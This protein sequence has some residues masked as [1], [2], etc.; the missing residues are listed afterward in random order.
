MTTEDLKKIWPEWQVEEQIGR[1][2]YGIVYKAIRRDH[3]V[4]NFAAIKVISIPT[5]AS[6][7]D[8][9]RSEGFDIDASRAYFEEIVNSFV[10]EIQLMV[11]LKGIQNIVSVED[12]KVVEKTD[13]IGWDIYIR[14][15]LLTPFNTYICDKKL[16]EAEV[17]KLGCDI[18]SALE[19]CGKR[20]IIHRDI[21]PENIFVNDFGDFK[22]GDFGIA[23]KLE[24]STIGFSQKGTY[25]Y[26]APEVTRGTDYD[27]RVDIYSLGIVL[28]RLMNNNRLPFLDTEKQLLNP[29]ER[30]NAVERRI[31]GEALLPPCDAS[32]EMADLILRA[33]A[34]DPDQRFSS[35]SVM[36]HNLMIIGKGTYNMAD[37]NRTVSVR[38]VPS[39]L[40]KTVSVNRITESGYYQQGT[41]VGNFTPKKKN[42]LPLAIAAI[43]IVIVLAIAGVFAV[44]MMMN[45]GGED[46]S[47]DGSNNVGNSGVIGDRDEADSEQEQINSILA[48]AEDLAA[49]NDYKGALNIIRDGLTTHP[50]S[51]ELQTKADE[52]TAVI[53]EQID[54]IIT[55]AEKFAT[56]GQYENAIEMIQSCLTTYPE[57]EK[58]ENKIQEYEAALN[59]TQNIKVEDVVGQTETYAISALETQ[60]FKVTVLESH[61]SSVA[62]GNV[63]RQDPNGGTLQPYGSKVTIYVSLGEDNNTSTTPSAPQITTDIT[64]TQPTS[65]SQSSSR[66]TIEVRFDANGGEVNTQSKYVYYSEPYGTLPTPTRTGYTFIGWFTSPNG[67]S[68]VL[69]DT[70]VSV[71]SNQTLYARWAAKTYTLTLNANGGNISQS[72]ISVAYGSAYGTLPTPTK[73]YN[74][75]IGWFTSSTGG[76]QVDSSTIMGDKNVTIYAHWTLKPESDWV[77]SSEVPSGAQI[78]Q[79]KWTYTRTET[80]ESTEASLSGWTQIGSYWKQTG[81]GTYSYAT[82]PSGF[83]TSDSLYSKYNHSALKP[84]ETST[85]KREVSSASLLLYI[86]WHWSRPN[87]YYGGNVTPNNRIVSDEKTSKYTQFAAFEVA[88]NYAHTHTDSKGNTDSTLYFYN[89]KNYTD[90][91]WWW[92]RFAVYKQTYTDYQ[93]IFKYQRIT[94]CESNTEIF[95]GGEISNVQKYVKYRPK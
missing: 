40:D 29:N 18:C 10:S 90:I 8:S 5:D 74:N 55:E 79:T 58:L 53:D 30:R 84:S 75:F 81:T 1:G 25:N 54:A 95:N 3:N 34:F 7:M 94:Y 91:S 27:A 89:R 83:N 76:S 14:M 47:G 12:Y 28:Y 50:E 80:K 49:K 85:T 68:Q 93:K 19:I 78:T 57:S 38:P 4:E 72:S 13:G 32:P 61:D 35:A 63:I 88:S 92:W 20:N 46:S 22:L 71:T 42:K 65:G 36:K 62:K 70:K 44:P 56:I 52:Y 37:I 41:V 77:L 11:S 2:S 67:G 23:R 86:Y 87:S 26:M 64:T 33:C 31:K 51:E 39:T 48:N 59:G 66:Q 60:G 9:L 6:E 82:Y 69:A 16:S 73:D 45:N 24:N 17:I 43:A 15:E 21:K